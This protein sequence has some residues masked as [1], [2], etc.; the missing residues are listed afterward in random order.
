VTSDA[1]KPSREQ[2]A[3]RGAA[4][5]GHQDRGAGRA[6]GQSRHGER[7]HWSSSGGPPFK[8]EGGTKVSVSVVASQTSPFNYY[9]TPIFRNMFGL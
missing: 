1:S 5:V 3:R 2:A 9:V 6:A 4:Q 8:I 7:L